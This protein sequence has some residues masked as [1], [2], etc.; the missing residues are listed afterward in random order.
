MT[1]GDAYERMREAIAARDA[2]FERPPA[3]TIWRGRLDDQRHPHP[4]LL[5]E[6]AEQHPMDEAAAAAL[7]RL[8]V[9]EGIAAVLLYML[10]DMQVLQPA[11][12]EFVLVDNGFWSAYHGH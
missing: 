2:A 4:L 8:V 10:A 7:F 5:V 1:T 6:R 11:P 12:G 3:L 9:D